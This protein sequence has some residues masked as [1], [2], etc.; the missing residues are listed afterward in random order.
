MNKLAYL[1]GYLSKQAVSDK[2]IKKTSPFLGALMDGDAGKLID[3]I[4][5]VDEAGI[6]K[7][8]NKHVKNVTKGSRRLG[9]RMNKVI[10]PD[11]MLEDIGRM[12]GTEE[13]LAKL[14][15]FARG[16]Y[17]ILPPEAQKQFDELAPIFTEGQLPGAEEAKKLFDVLKEQK[18]NKNVVKDVAEE[19]VD[20]AAKE[21][22]IMDSVKDVFKDDNGDTAYWV[23][24]TATGIGGAALGGGLT[25]A[26]NKKRR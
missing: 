22:G 10:S 3:R 11:K 16:K 2:W 8:V 17:H 5:D 13:G 15:D 18:V 12:A 14:T 21:G 25:Y 26:L 9:D 4:K 7:F 23:A 1:E 20:D 24:P 6:N 19:A